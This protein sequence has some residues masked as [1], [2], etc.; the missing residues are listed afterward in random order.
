MKNQDST[1]LMMNQSKSMVVVVLMVT[2]VVGAVNGKQ[3]TGPKRAIMCYSCQNCDD[4]GVTVSC[5]E[6]REGR[7]VACFKEI[8]CK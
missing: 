5:A 8:I 7:G 4:K 3:S 1:G 2:L 6:R